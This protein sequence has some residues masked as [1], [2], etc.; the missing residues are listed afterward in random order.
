M[1]ILMMVTKGLHC[2]S[3]ID[4]ILGKSCLTAALGCLVDDKILLVYN[5]IDIAHR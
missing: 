4:Y 1:Y 2:R 3:S 5:E